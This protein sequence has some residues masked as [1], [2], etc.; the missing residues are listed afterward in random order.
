MR[1]IAYIFWF[2]LFVLAI[3]FAVLNAEHVALNYYFGTRQVSL[4]LLMLLV[5]VIGALLGILVLLPRLIR[6]KSRHR[7]LRRRLKKHEEE[8]QNLRALPIKDD[9]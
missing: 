9:D 8:V 7:R 2:I 3:S 6:L 1:Y 4:P 5:F